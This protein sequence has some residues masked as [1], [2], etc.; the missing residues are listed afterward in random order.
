MSGSAHPAAAN[1]AN[2]YGDG[3]PRSA[4]WPGC[5][6]SWG[7]SARPGAAPRAVG[8]VI[9]VALDVG[10]YLERL[11]EMDREVRG[12]L[13]RGSGKIAWTGQTGTQAPLSLHVSGSM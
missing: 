13:P 4:S 10:R 1:A 11:E 5:G 9:R 12:R 6:A 3:P 8:Y 2:P 7:R